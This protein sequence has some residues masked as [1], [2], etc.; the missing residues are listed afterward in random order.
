M[1]T[2]T[3]DV[4]DDYVSN[5]SLALGPTSPPPSSSPDHAT[6]AAA[7]DGIAGGRRSVVR[8]GVRLFPCL[9]CNKKFLKSQALGGHQNAH[10]KERSVGWN[11]QYLY[12]TAAES[13]TAVAGAAVPAMATTSPAINQA[14][15]SSPMAVVVRPIQVSHSCR[16]QRALHLDGDTSARYA[17]A[18]VGDGG[19]GLSRWW[20]TDQ[21]SNKS[22]TLAG[23]EKQQRHVDL[24]LKL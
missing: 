9:F 7:S 12:L 21:G 3:Y 13:S 18:H 14:S 10:K 5:L 23:E 15:S 22:C 2:F 20:Y 11:A 24:N 17:G 19:H 6:A 4:D 8:G 16:P 1:D